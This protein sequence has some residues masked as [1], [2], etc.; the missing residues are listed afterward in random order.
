SRQCEDLMGKILLTSKLIAEL[1]SISTSLSHKA[2]NLKSARILLIAEDTERQHR[3][4]VLNVARQ[5]NKASMAAYIAQT[6]KA[7]TEMLSL[8]NK[9]HNNDLKLERVR[10]ERE[11]LE[12]RLEED[13]PGNRA[14]ISHISNR[15]EAE[16]EITRIDGEVSSLGTIRIA[17]ID[18]LARLE[19]RLS[20]LTKEKDDLDGAMAEL[21]QIIKVLDLTMSEKF[22]ACFGHIKVTFAEIATRM[23]GGAV[24]RLS[25]AE[26]HRPLDS[27]IE[28]DIQPAGKR[29]QN[30]NLLSGGERA[31]AALALLC[32]VLKVNPT[33]FCILDEIDAP[34]DD[35][36]VNRLIPILKELS[37]MTQFLLITHTKGTMAASD[38]LY[39]V[40][41]PEQG[42]SQ[43]VAVRVSEIARAGGEAK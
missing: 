16:T 37:L 25:L 26:P 38:T 15:A 27:G 24:A 42:V 32:S 21:M 23:F 3:L 12:R 31:L 8:R 20:H 35:A 34:L 17:S 5:E 39:G 28:I 30:I 36:N 4:S 10:A 43:V 19:E 9:L 2:D 7:V 22:L 13:F 41:M 33:P 11:Y 29:L 1:G 40:T 18:E 14:K 6:G